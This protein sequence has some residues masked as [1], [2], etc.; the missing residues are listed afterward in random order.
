MV[1]SSNNGKRSMSNAMGVGDIL[2][3]L[4][5]GNAARR[6]KQELTPVEVIKIGRRYFTVC[7]AGNKDKDWTHT[8]FLLEDLSE[9]TGYTPTQK[10]YRSREDYDNEIEANEIFSRIKIAFSGYR[11]TNFT[12]EQLRAIRS[13]IS[14]PDQ[15]ETEQRE[16]IIG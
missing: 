2:Y 1:S 6:Q 15:Q 10:L 9:K 5:V 13:I 8:Q 7:E 12:L 4:N 3:S 16:T 14:N 11:N